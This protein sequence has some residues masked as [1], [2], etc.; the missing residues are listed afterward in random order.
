MRYEWA[1]V[2][3]G[4]AG[5]VVAEILAR[6]GHRVVLV[7]ESDQLAAGTTGLFHEWI[8]TG[9]LYTLVPDKLHTLKFL[10]GA[11]DDLLEY[12]SAFERMNVK[13]TEAGLRLER[14]H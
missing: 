13:P 4:I 9:C 11:V 3:G 1:V 12:Y 6:E 5:I 7:E 14:L 2:G 8:H 10:L